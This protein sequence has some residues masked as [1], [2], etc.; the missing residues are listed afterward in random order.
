M[1]ALDSLFHHLVK[2]YVNTCAGLSLVVWLMTTE[3]C[4]KVV[5]RAE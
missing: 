1:K 2:A 5:C 4:E 3:S